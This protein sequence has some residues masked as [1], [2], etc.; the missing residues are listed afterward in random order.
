MFATGSLLGY[1]NRDPEIGQL[2]ICS[3]MYTL[4]L[5]LTSCLASLRTFGAERV[6]HWREAARGA[7]MGLDSTAYFLAK[8]LVDVPRVFL[9]TT[10]LAV[11]FYPQVSGSVVR[12]GEGVHFCGFLFL[13]VAPRVSCP[14]ADARLPPSPAVSHC[15]PP[16]ATRLSLLPNHRPHH[17]PRPIPRSHPARPSGS[18][19]S[20]RWRPHGQ[21]RA[22]PTS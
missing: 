2:P 13:P 17:Q 5:G 1:I 3:F 16:S 7:G 6:V 11:S 18:S 10:C 21:S 20:C 15:L 9:L 14:C 19:W 22:G 8:N 4:G 12:H